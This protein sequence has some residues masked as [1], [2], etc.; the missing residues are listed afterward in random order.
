MLLSPV[1]TCSEPRRV[2]SHPRLFVSPSSRDLCVLS[3]SALDCS[4]SLVASTFNFQSKI[5]TRS[6]PLTFNL[7]PALSPLAATLM[8]LPANVANKR[9]MPHVNPLDATLTKNTGAG[10][11]SHFGKV[12]TVLTTRT[13]ISP[14]FFPFTFFRT[15][16]HDAKLNSFI[17]NGLRT[18]CLKTPGGQKSICQE[19]TQINRCRRG[20]RNS[21]PG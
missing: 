4:F 16:L 7:P 14:K 12:C 3:V 21:V 2:E 15:L 18:L 17:F 9:L 13:R 20:A 10:Y 19:E 11:P 1:Y 5:A 8:N 6:G